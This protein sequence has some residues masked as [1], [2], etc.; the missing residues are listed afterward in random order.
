M[1]NAQSYGETG[2][3]IVYDLF[4]LLVQ[5][6]VRKFL[7]QEIRLNGRYLFLT[8]Q[9]LKWTP[10]NWKQKQCDLMSHTLLLVKWFRS[11]I[12]VPAEEGWTI[13]GSSGSP[14]IVTSISALTGSSS[15]GSSFTT[16]RVLG[17]TPGM[18]ATIIFKVTSVPVPR[19]SRSRV[20]EKVE[21]EHEGC[22]KVY[23]IKIEITFTTNT[24][25]DNK[26]CPLPVK[27]L[28]QYKNNGIEVTV[29]T[30]CQNTDKDFYK[31]YMSDLFV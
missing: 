1:D 27:D 21:Y 20:H 28:E 16:T 7:D 6:N 13:S 4:I 24:D 9:F 10:Q 31:T 18:R 19:L 30:R 14:F 2:N 17:K 15:N 3:L 26:N 25:W 23:W 12:P 8:K 29:N 11:P 5:I 22:K